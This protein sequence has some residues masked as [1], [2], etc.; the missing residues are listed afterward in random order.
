MLTPLPC[1][2]SDRRAWMLDL[3]SGD[4][5]G[6]QV[7]TDDPPAYPVGAFLAFYCPDRDVW[8]DVPSRPFANAPVFNTLA[9]K[10]ARDFGPTRSN[11]LLFNCRFA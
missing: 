6:R 10:V 3:R 5:V 2:R 4:I 9:L 7:A 11:P 8:C 1:D